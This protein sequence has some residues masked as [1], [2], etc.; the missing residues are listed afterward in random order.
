MGGKQSVYLTHEVLEE[1]QSESVRQGKS[2]SWLVQEAWR[3][4]KAELQRLNSVPDADRSAWA[5]RWGTIDDAR[6]DT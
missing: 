6:D 2:L 1:L 3:I 5:E 4:S